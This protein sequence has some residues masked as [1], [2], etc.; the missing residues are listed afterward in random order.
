MHR[1]R[2]SFHLFNISRDFVFFTFSRPPIPTLGCIIRARPRPN[3]V[4]Y[5]IIRWLYRIILCYTVLLG[6]E[7]HI[8]RIINYT[9]Y[10]NFTT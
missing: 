7:Y 4:L 1:E 8:I 10:S 3:T 5:G 9:I 6:T 2:H